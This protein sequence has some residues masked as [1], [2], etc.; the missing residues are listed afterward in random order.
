MAEILSASGGTENQPS[1]YSTSSLCFP[2]VMAGHKPGSSKHSPAQDCEQVRRVNIDAVSGQFWIDPNLGCSSDSIL[3]YCNFTSNQTCIFPRENQVRG[4][5]GKLGEV[6]KVMH[7]LLPTSL[8]VATTTSYC[9]HH[10]LLHPSLPISLITTYCTHH[11]LSHPITSYC[12]HHFLFHSSLPIVPISSYC[13]HHFLLHP[14]LPIAPIT[15]YCIHHFLLHP[16]LPTA[17]ITTYCTHHYLLHPS[18]PTAPITSYC[19]HHF[20][21]HPSLPI[22]PQLIDGDYSH[23]N[24]LTD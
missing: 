2:L 24:A 20:L 9:T 10:F 11:F 12:T 8:P 3:V 19:A 16:S 15:S 13:T 14:S 6:L 5:V 17:P 4:N 7:P 23:V 22:A 1:D 21:L 18:L